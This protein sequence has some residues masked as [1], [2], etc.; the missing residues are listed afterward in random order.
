MA[1]AMWISAAS[2]MSAGGSY[3]NR[4]DRRGLLT[5]DSESESIQSPSQSRSQS[6]VKPVVDV[7]VT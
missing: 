2:L 6:Q 5:S 4:L 1:R 7:L 3:A